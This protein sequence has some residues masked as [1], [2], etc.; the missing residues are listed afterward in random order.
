MLSSVAPAPGAVARGH[1][2]DEP[3]SL[4]RRWVECIVFAIYLGASLALAIAYNHVLVPSTANDFFWFHYNASVQAFLMDAI[5][6]LHSMSSA[7]TLISLTSPMF[8]QDR[9]Y[10]ADTT[11]LVE[12]QRSYPRHLLYTLLTDLESHIES[13]RSMQAVNL[14]W[15]P[16][17][18]CWVDFAKAWELGHTSRRQQRCVNRY[19]RN[20][21]MYLE[22]MLRNT[23]MKHFMAALG[24]PDGEFTV[25]IHRALNKSVAGRSFMERLVVEPWLTVPDEA[26]YWRNQNATEWKLQYMNWKQTGSSDT[27]SINSALGYVY[28]MSVNVIP[29]SMMAF[30]WTTFNMYAEFFNDL[31][32]AQA[33]N[34][35][36][37]RS[38]EYFGAE[39]IE[40]NV[41]MGG[42]LQDAI[43]ELL[44]P[45]NSI[46][47]YLVPLPSPLVALYRRFRSQAYSTV[48]LGDGSNA[49]Q[50][51]W[52]E[53][54]PSIRVI[55]S[56]QAWKNDSLVFLG[57]SPLCTFN[58]TTPFLQ[59]EWGFDDL[60]ESPTPLESVLTRHSVLFAV[61][62]TS[63]SSMQ[64]VQASR[65]SNICLWSDDALACESTLTNA[66]ALVDV[67]LPRFKEEEA[68]T[69]LVAQVESAIQAL[70]VEIIQFASVVESGQ[71]VLL[72]QVVLDATDPLITF[73]GWN[74]L[75]NWVTFT[76]EVVFYD[77]DEASLNLLSYQYTTNFKLQ[78]NL[79]Q[80]PRNVGGLLMYGVWYVSFVLTIVAAV[81]LF[82]VL[83]AGV[84]DSSRNMLQFHRVASFTWVGRP[85]LLL[86]G[87]TAIALVSS[88]TTGLTSRH[89]VTW[90]EHVPRSTWQSLL[91]ASEV[92]WLS[93]IMSDVGLLVAETYSTWT[94]P[95]SALM[96]FIAVLVL[97]VMYP[98]DLTV[99]TNNRTCQIIDLDA[100]VFC[101]SAAIYSGSFERTLAI[102]CATIGSWLVCT[103]SSY[104]RLLCHWRFRP[105]QDSHVLYPRA[106]TAFFAL[107]YNDGGRSWLD[108][109]SQIMC[110]ILP[111]PK[112]S[113]G[114][115]TWHKHYVFSVTSW[116]FVDLSSSKPRQVAV[117]K[118][119][120]LESTKAATNTAQST[121][122][123]SQSNVATTV[124]AKQF[125]F[126]VAALLYVG[127]TLVSSVMY[128]GVLQG[129][130]SN[131]AWWRGFNSTGVHYYLAVL[132]NNL[133]TVWSQPS[134]R[135]VLELDQAMYS[136]RGFYN[137]STNNEI[138]FSPAYA[139]ATT[140]HVF[141]DLLAVITALRNMDGCHAPWIATQY[142][143]VD[144]EKEWELANTLQRQ[145]RCERHDSRNAAVF[146][147]SILRNVPRSEF[148]ACWGHSFQV[149]IANELEVSQAGRSWL[150]ATLSVTLSSE[151][152]EVS[153]WRSHGLD[154]FHTQWQNYKVS[155]IL[156]TIDAVNAFGVSYPL[157][158]KQSNGTWRFEAQTTFK[159]YWMWGSDLW[160][161]GQATNQSSVISG[162]SLV[163]SSSRYAFANTSM[164]NVLVHNSTLIVPLV[165]SAQLF[166]DTFGPFGSIDMK[167]IA[168]P[169]TAA[170]FLGEFHLYLSKLLYANQNATDDFALIPAR[171]YMAYL[172]PQWTPDNNF[173]FGGGNPL[174]TT[175]G[176]AME[177]F[178]F[179]YLDL[180]SPCSQIAVREGSYV[181]PGEVFFAIAAART[182]NSTISPSGMCDQATEQSNCRRVMTT[183]WPYAMKYLSQSLSSQS[184]LTV[185][186]TLHQLDVNLFQYG[187]HQGR[188]VITTANAFDMTIAGGFWGW[189]YLHQWA[190]GQ[191]EVVCL[192][193]DIA[194]V[195]LLT[196]V[197]K[198]SACTLN[199]AEIP[200]SLSLYFMRGVQYVTIML[201]MV[202]SVVV[203]ATVVVSWGNVE[204]W[205]LFKINRVGGIVWV[206]RPL[207]FLRAT[208]AI[209]LL[210][211]GSLE[212]EVMPTTRRTKFSSPPPTTAFSVLET[213]LISGEVCWLTYVLNDMLTVWT[214]ENTKGYAWRSSLLLW[215]VASIL[216]VVSP[217]NVSATLQRQC[218]TVN[219]DLQMVCSSGMIAIGNSSRFAHLLY[220]SLGSTA[221]CYAVEKYRRPKLPPSRIPS[222]L[223]YSLSVY[224]FPFVNWTDSDGH[225]Y[226]DAASAFLNG[227]IMVPLKGFKFYVLDIKT[228]R[229]FTMPMSQHPR[230]KRALVLPPEQSA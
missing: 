70:S 226:L 114:A 113:R 34:F 177:K 132:A 131:D 225:V 184:A 61:A 119:V 22:A 170:S 134:V 42:L 99:N 110:G 50:T 115:L 189:S 202:A 143:W 199:P 105:Q 53:M 165:W 39:G 20:A 163:R 90:L 32:A 81:L 78:P 51:M 140:Y 82:V 215:L 28:N 9:P 227:L 159:M 24:G 60:C 25:A 29:Y 14:V 219:F 190:V 123:P 87:V 77:G 206:G 213:C 218:R 182:I 157:T 149:A 135:T 84:H 222:L 122:Q 207:L 128:L 203:I 31:Y 145:R 169:A 230:F 4:V 57:G 164:T 108:H 93:Y 198:S 138:A 73:L 79:D 91:V 161:V 191:R 43:H 101:Q 181:P 18:Y 96:S 1:R 176:P 187:L 200:H 147:E 224:T 46:D 192:T 160:A 130:L 52:L 72:R 17:Q 139:H 178:A 6:A 54:A 172:P 144:F 37:I 150:F 103:A 152:D 174:C 136:L 26:S 188:H 148:L 86:R 205:N 155:G 21:A 167:Y 10:G 141:Q 129:R 98:L 15:V 183:A 221:V 74:Y 223:L 171:T 120:P 40:S 36:L 217:P 137:I 209:A 100:N 19:T 88:S 133:P 11:L 67:F 16:T 106:S 83:A 210:S 104:S 71:P 89:G 153:T 58:M 44:G 185:A 45:L 35:S 193:G 111:V 228:W 204:P 127:V 117:A 162:R 64:F 2:G 49:L 33:G 102:V 154:S 95:V 5:N 12:C 109:G 151:V 196:A 125:L 75:F 116:L 112:I 63:L 8:A 214:K 197:V 80:L 3:P 166:Q 118:L 48:T 62:M 38:D 41:Y 23:D 69:S 55:P 124:S 121:R 146:L 156:E 142:C 66:H 94:A 27:V 107:K 179:A 208:S 7:P 13:M 126:V 229:V 97:D 220:L 168:M 158:L 195:T 212:L 186:K 201:M 65:L 92:T 173:S 211:T 216:Q 59:Q 68:A 194:S 180:L 56:I 76:R 30:Q 85:L 47:L 175:I